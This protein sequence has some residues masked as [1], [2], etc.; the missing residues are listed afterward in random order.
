MFLLCTSLPHLEFTVND[1]G[2]FFLIE[3]KEHDDLVNPPQE[4]ITS[5]SVLEDRVDLAVEV[6]NKTHVLFGPSLRLRLRNYLAQVRRLPL[7]LIRRE[8][9]S[10]DERCVFTVNHASLDTR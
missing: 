10:H 3:G 7:D 4:L 5:Q 9:G 2:Y 8:I 1:N 6:A